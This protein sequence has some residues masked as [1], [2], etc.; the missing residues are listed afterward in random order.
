MTYHAPLSALEFPFPAAINPLTQRAQE[1]TRE[2]TYRFGLIRGATAVRR[3]KLLRSGY[4]GGR[5]YPR[6]PFEGLALATDWI[7]WLFQLDDHLDE[8]PPGLLAATTDDL[9]GQ[10]T[11]ALR[12][13]EPF[14][15]TPVSRALASLWRRTARQTSAAWQRRYAADLIEYLRSP[16]HQESSRGP[17][18]VP[19]LEPYLAERRR[20][21]GMFLALDMVEATERVEVPADVAASPEYRE[22]RAATNDVASWTN[23][24][25]SQATDLARG[26]ADNL[27]VVLQHQRRCCTDAAVRQATDMIH[28]RVEDFLAAKRALPVAYRRLALSPDSRDGLADCVAGYEAWMRGNR[29]WS[30]ETERYLRVEHT[31]QA[32]VP[33]R[34]GP[35]PIVEAVA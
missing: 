14:A 29:D 33:R 17:G 26:R 11:A 32:R 18:R 8:L 9:P 35:L 31:P 21:S 23:D 24:I 30:L 22:L 27:V 5:T 3:F 13:G 1:H 19:E 12:P 15:D 4:L 6:V 20:G 2:W 7:S 10:I 25:A 34:V 16:R 28:A